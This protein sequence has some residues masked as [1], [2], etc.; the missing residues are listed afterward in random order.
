MIAVIKT[1]RVAGDDGFTRLQGRR[2]ASPAPLAQSEMAAIGNP[3]PADGGDPPLGLVSGNVACNPGGDP[4]GRSV[5]RGDEDRPHSTCD[6]AA[7]A[8]RHADGREQGYAAGFAAGHEAGHVAGHEAGL[9]Q[10]LARGQELC[11]E[12]AEQADRRSRAQSEAN[13]RSL[14]ALGEQIVQSTSAWQAGAEELAVEIA[15]TALLRL[16][17]ATA[18]QRDTVAGMVASVLEQHRQRHVLS[19]HLAPGDFALVGQH[20]E[21]LCAGNPRL[22]P[23]D[24]VQ[25]GGCI[26]ETDAGGLDARLESQLGELRTVLLAQLASRGQAA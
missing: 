1:V 8:D 11:Q 2:Q 19:I 10:G 21:A 13:A 15:W 20:E 23:D 24:R 7:Q 5:I 18:G 3:A 25:L 17:G 12:R 26:I 9:E 4:Y 6:E 22:V 16:L 14:Q